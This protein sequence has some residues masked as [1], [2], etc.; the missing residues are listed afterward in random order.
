[1]LMFDRALFVSI[2][3]ICAASTVAS[4]AALNVPLPRLIDLYLMPS[5]LSLALLAIV[6]VIIG[7]IARCDRPNRR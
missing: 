7:E 4:K 5:T 2:V 1:M 3:L 6:A